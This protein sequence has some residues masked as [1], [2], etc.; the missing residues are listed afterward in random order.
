MLKARKIQNEF[1]RLKEGVAERDSITKT[2]SPKKT[3]FN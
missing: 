3:V 2:A 1:M